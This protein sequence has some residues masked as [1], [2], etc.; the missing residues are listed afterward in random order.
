MSFRLSIGT[1]LLSLVILG[2]CSKTGGTPAESQNISGGFGGGGVG[3]GVSRS[4][5]DAG[6]LRA[7]DL[8]AGIKMGLVDSVAAGEARR[9]FPGVPGNVDFAGAFRLTGSGTLSGATVRMSTQDGLFDLRFPG[10]D[11]Q[12]PVVVYLFVAKVRGGSGLGLADASAIAIDVKC[13]GGKCSAIPPDNGSKGDSAGDHLSDSL[14]SYLDDS[15]TGGGGSSGSS[16]GGTPYGT[17]NPP[18]C[19][20]LAELARQD[21][22]N[23]CWGDDLKGV[24]ERVK[25]LREKGP[26]FEAGILNCIHNAFFDY[27]KA[28]N[29]CDGKA[30]DPCSR[31]SQ[32]IPAKEAN[33][34]ATCAEI[35]DSKKDQ[36]QK[37]EDDLIKWTNTYANK[38]KGGQAP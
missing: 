7:M 38:C 32:T 13:D 20:Q 10:R 11:V 1:M 16:S 15:T 30:P 19:Q 12:T 3:G 33:F 25:A 21:A 36:C 29:E 22:Q 4:S 37:L 23:A 9:E 27:A 26:E 8:P 18:T 14:S 31:M 35:T 24:V 28:L 6:Q 5:A 17:P 2:A 34:N